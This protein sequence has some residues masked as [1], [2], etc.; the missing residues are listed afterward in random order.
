MQGA[1]HITEQ[2]A[3]GEQIKE[4][5]EGARDSVVRLPCC[6]GGVGDG[7]LADTGAVPG[8]EGGNKAMHLAVERDVLDDL[9]AIGLEGGAEVVD[10]DVAEDRHEPVGRARGNA[11]HDE[12]VAAMLAPAT[13]DVVAF[14]QFG[15]EVGD[16]VGVVLEIAVHGED[17]VALGVVEAGGEGGGLAEVAAELDD[18]NPTVDGGDFFKQAVGA[19]AGSIVDED[20]FEGFADLLHYGFESVVE[21]GDV[22]FFVMERNDDGIFRHGLMILLWLRFSGIAT[23]RKNDAQ[24]KIHVNSAVNESVSSVVRESFPLREWPNRARIRNGKVT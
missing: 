11:A 22:F 19:V 6:A 5:A 16:L 21:G 3:D 10:V 7:N 15:E 9:A 23:M 13:D 12:V 1:G 24:G 14:F 8:G 17:E 4:D 18:E 20:Q 2:E